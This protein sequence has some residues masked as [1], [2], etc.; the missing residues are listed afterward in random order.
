MTEM[1]R[2]LRIVAPLA[3]AIALMSACGGKAPPDQLAELQALRASP[4]SQDIQQDAS[5]IENAAVRELR[6]QAALMLRA[7]DRY[8]EQ[9]EQQWRKSRRDPT[10][11]MARTG[12]LYYRAAENYYRASE[13]RERLSGANASL[14]SQLERRNDFMERLQGEEELISMLE[15][16]EELFERNED[17]RRQLST[18]HEQA[19]AENRAVY[20]IQ[21]ARMQMR[22]AEGMR[23][24]Q[25]AV[26]TFRD[27]ERLLTRA[28]TRFEDGRHED[29][30]EIALQ[31]IDV[32]NQASEE[33]RPSFLSEQ[34]R[35]LS[36]D[37]N[38]RIYEEAQRTFGDRVQ[39][40]VRG[41]VIVLPYLFDSRA[42]S[43]R[44]TQ[45][46]Q[47]DML[48]EL[49]RQ[50]DRFNVSIEGHSDDRASEESALTLSETRAGTVQA[51]LQQRGIQA[52]RL[53]I[54]GFGSSHPAYDNS[55]EE[56]RANNNRVEIVFG[57]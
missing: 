15:T 7:A 2:T 43:I 39:I 53:S 3:I 40:D 32:F 5:D 55:T 9:A 44:E 30:Y 17:L 57:L 33:A 14:Q 49:I 48:V 25:H 12:L 4:L 54:A 19:R 29:A 52:R 50:Y 37:Y 42:A 13:A 6:E 27:A 36:N 16:I 26:E 22:A 35:L 46:E 24:N 38:R 23:A 41:L 1:K 51:Y 10:V 31:A 28:Q 56:G 18:V 21:E 20:A 11:T 8:Q 45:T 47:L 34:D